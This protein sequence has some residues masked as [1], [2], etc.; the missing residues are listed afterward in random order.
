MKKRSQTELKWQNLLNQFQ[1]SNQSAREWCQQ[2]NICYH[3]FLNWKKRLQSQKEDRF[4][5]LK[6]EEPIELSWKGIRI[7]FSPS[8]GLSPL[9]SLL[10]ALC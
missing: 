9:K 1:N 10:E 7:S 8:D 3:S 4:I 5:E 2:N 6:Q